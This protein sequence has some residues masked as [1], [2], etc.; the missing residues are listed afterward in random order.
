V[1][2]ALRAGVGAQYGRSTFWLQANGPGRTPG[3]GL[4]QVTPSSVP[5]PTGRWLATC[6]I[7]FTFTAWLQYS[8]LLGPKLSL[9][10]LDLCGGALLNANQAVI[11]RFDGSDNLVQLHLYGRL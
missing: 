6:P 7:T 9:Q 2:S 10:R 11:G 5:G 8:I 1:D 3:Q 4:Q